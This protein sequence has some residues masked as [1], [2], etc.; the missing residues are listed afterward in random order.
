[1]DGSSI[2][3]STTSE[4]KSITSPRGKKLCRVGSGASVIIDAGVEEAES[5][6]APS[7]RFKG[8]VSQPNARWG[9]QIYD[10][11][12]RVWIG[13]FKDE[14][15]AARAYDVASHRFRGR[16]AIANFNP[17]SEDEIVDMLRKHTY[18]D[19]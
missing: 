1:M 5:Q 19:E 9:A 7:S 2:D 10:K 16:D 8:V 17:L 18:H 3:Q 11:H 13:T 14:E 4:S 12:K 6:K 15:V